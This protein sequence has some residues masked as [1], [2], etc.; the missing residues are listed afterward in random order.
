MPEQLSFP[1][2]DPAPT[3][4]LFFALFPDAP[5]ARCTEEIARRL[6][7]QRGLTGRPLAS[8]RFHV[9]LHCLGDYAGVPNEIVAKAH[10]A[11]ANLAAAPFG[12]LFD[13]AGSFTGRQRKLPL[14]LRS[15][16]SPLPLIAFQ[17][18]LGEA[19]ARN[20]LGRFVSPLYTPHMTLL[21]D[22]RYIEPRPIEP[23]GW[24]VR[25]FVLVRSLV[26]LTMHIPLARWR[27]RGAAVEPA[28][29]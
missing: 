4:R 7:D 14:V 22:A 17:Q 1:S 13:L 23:V 19:M 24:T 20:G 21:Y 29:Q 8:R 27:L 3:D 6:R 11:A 15:G 18:A 2:L 10:D 28:H 12:V 5:A 25:E 9:S 26:G 16:D